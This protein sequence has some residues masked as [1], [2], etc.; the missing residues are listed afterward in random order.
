MFLR[1]G[2]AAV[3][4]SAL[5]PA[6]AACGKGPAAQVSSA[7]QVTLPAYQ[8]FNG[9]APDLPGNTAGVPAGYYRYPASP[10]RSVPAPPLSGET[11]SAVTNLYLPPP[12]GAG[13]NP[14]WAEI[15]KRLGATVS[16][17]MVDATDYPTK[18]ATLVA[19]G[20][21]PDIM[22]YVGGVN[23]FDAFLETDIADLSPYL[24]GDA[25][26]KYPNLAAIPEIFWKQCT[27]AGKLYFLPIPRNVTAGSGFYN[28]A[29]FGKAGV[30]DTRSIRDVSDFTA[31]CKDLT[32]PGSG[33]YALSAYNGYLIMPILHAYRVPF[34][35]TVQGGK[36]VKDYETEEFTEAVAYATQ[37]YKAGVYMP[38]SVGWT[39][40]QG[41]N[42]LESG[43]VAYTYDGFPAYSKIW[44]AMQQTS[45]GQT[46]RAFIPFGWN[47]GKGI[48]Y[49]D[50]I[51]YGNGV[52]LKKQSPDRIRAALEVANFLAAPFGT[53]EYLLI[54]YGAEGTD[55]KMSGGNPVLTSKGTT[56]VAVP[57]TYIEAPEL[58]L[59]DQAAGGKP[60]VDAA[61]Q[62]LSTLIPMAVADPTAT[63]FSPTYANDYITLA[64]AMQNTTNQII[65][66]RQPVSSLKAAVRQ[67]QRQGGDK[68]RGE[69]EK[70]MA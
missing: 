28:Q 63:L 26:K 6:L 13:S 30:S 51:M 49:Q 37:L 11:V 39:S 12:P 45:P 33:K 54:N 24:G 62:A 60:Y 16:V 69:F 25:I 42:A 34:N 46:A 47:G 67:W 4:G 50:N 2:A 20:N 52:M 32:R 21:L 66:G 5:L 40:T 70:A 65:S 3:A 38:G 19:G 1:G 17:N 35:W 7:K 56:D 57:W 31:V 10:V 22:L 53:E 44:P 55:Y 64:T 61:H 68:M 29:L 18:F 27:A 15:Q 59:Y 9:P 43:K 23:D 36:L 8:P 14:A 58:V 41:D 48:A